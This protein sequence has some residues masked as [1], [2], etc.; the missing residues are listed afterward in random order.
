MCNLSDSLK[1]RYVI[2]GVADTL[3]VYGLGSVVN[4]RCKVLRLITLDEF[5]V[6]SESR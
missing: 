6:D 4:G 5:G 1:V 2:S 3:E